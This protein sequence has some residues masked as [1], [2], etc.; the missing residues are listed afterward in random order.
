VAF[1]NLLHR[2]YADCLS[3]LLGKPVSEDM[4][5][6]AFERLKVTRKHIHKIAV[7][8]D[9]IRCA[10]CKLPSQI[11]FCVQQLD[12]HQLPS[13]VGCEGVSLSAL[14][15]VDES[16][17]FLS[18]SDRDMGY[19]FVG[20]KAEIVSTYTKGTKWTIMLAVGFRGLVN[21]WVHKENT[22]GAVCC[23]CF[24]FTCVRSWLVVVRRFM[25]NFWPT[26]FF[27]SWSTQVTF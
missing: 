22:T 12:V 17:A 4:V 24:R 19:S 6:E 2:T 23:C 14:V 13:A 3:R 15:D 20:H 1:P 26:S 21:Y 18:D 11:A 27:R 16:F 10:R 8:Q 5:A 7:E 9:P 25:V